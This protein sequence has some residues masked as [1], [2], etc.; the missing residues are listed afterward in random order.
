VDFV[1]VQ[2]DVSAADAA[3]LSE[4]DVLQLGQDFQDFADTAAV[5]AMLDLLIAVDT[6]IAHLGGAMGK[7]VALLVP[8]SPDFRWFLDRT[9][10]P[11]Y[12]T[13]RLFRQ[14]VIGDWNGPVEQVRRELTDVIS[15]RASAG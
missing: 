3:L 13:M 1:S 7:G 6:S 10:S 2:K 14:G 4:N 5:L 11:W 8:F 15:R 12:P 9:D